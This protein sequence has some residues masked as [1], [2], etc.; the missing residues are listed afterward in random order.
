[1]RSVCPRAPV[2]PVC[3]VCVPAPPGVFLPVI[4][5]SCEIESAGPSQSVQLFHVPPRAHS[6]A[7]SPSDSAAPVQTQVY[8][9]STEYSTLRGSG[10]TR[11]AIVS[12]SR[13]NPYTPNHIH[14]CARPLL[15]KSAIVPCVLVPGLFYQGSWNKSGKR[16]EELREEYS[17]PRRSTPTLRLTRHHRRPR[18][19]IQTHRSLP[20]SAR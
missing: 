6:S 16:K 10:G 5:S 15:G 9:T 18:L 19:Q 17:P 12:A 20:E 4:A 7:G 8:I 14:D 11:F 2:C 1:M 13:H 3:P